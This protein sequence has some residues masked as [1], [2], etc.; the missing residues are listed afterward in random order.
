[1]GTHKHYG[2][3]NAAQGVEGRRYTM[4]LGVIRNN[5]S[6]SGYWQPIDDAA[7]GPSFIDSVSTDASAITINHSSLGASK[8]ASF[9][10]FPDDTLA[11]AGITAGVSVGL[12]S[13][14]I[15]L[16]RQ[17]K[18]YSDYVSYSGSAWSSNSGVFTGI[19][20]TSGVLHLV[21]PAL[22]VPDAFGCSISPRGGAHQITVNGVSTTYLDIEFRNWS[23]TLITT[24]ASTMQAYITRGGH[25]V[26][27]NPQAVD[28]TA[29]P[30]SNLW[31]MGVFETD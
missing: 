7:H 24:A 11:A 16:Q 12:T 25:T 28:T 14:I 15:T 8:V 30:G 17:G 23:G 26:A 2:S 4:L 9:A 20:Y 5:G 27:L 10:I 29:Y 19:T 6:G 1:M 18:M 3:L 31:I 22:P 21:H 13:S